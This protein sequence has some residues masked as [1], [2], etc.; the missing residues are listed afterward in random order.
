MQDLVYSPKTFKQD[1]IARDH[2]GLP[3][4]RLVLVNDS[5][6][7]EGKPIQVALLSLPKS[8]ELGIVGLEFYIDETLYKLPETIPDFRVNTRKD[9]IIVSSV[10]VEVV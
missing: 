4:C 1:H 5:A 6:Y 8:F 3:L 9:C 7:T 2:R 10:T